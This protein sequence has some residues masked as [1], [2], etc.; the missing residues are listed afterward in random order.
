MTT[1]TAGSDRWISQVNAQPIGEFAEAP[2]VIRREAHGLRG[3]DD[4]F[5]VPHGT[6]GLTGNHPVARNDRFSTPLA[7][8]HTHTCSFRVTVRTGIGQVHRAAFGQL[9]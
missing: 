8:A 6:L 5:G 3:D 9:G 7:D 4:T 2:F 1:L